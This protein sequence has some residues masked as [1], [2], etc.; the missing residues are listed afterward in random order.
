MEKTRPTFARD[1]GFRRAVTRSVERYFADAE[2][3]PHGDRRMILKAAVTLA[4]FAASYA[5]LVF[6]A[7]TWW[8]G[9]GASLSLALATA[10]VGFNIQH[11]ANHG[12]FSKRRRVNRL[13]GLTIDVLGGSSFVWRATHNVFHHSYPNLDGA[14]RDI[15]LRPLARLA[16]T[17]P[18][19][20]VH[21][22][23]HYYLWL[24]YG[25]LVPAWHFKDVRCA[26]TGRVAGHRFPRPRGRALAELVAGK[27]L[28][29]GY[30]LVVPALF[31]P[32]LVV[33]SFYALTAFATGL[34]LSTVFQ[35][36]HCVVEA[37][38]PEPPRG[39]QMADGW[40]AHQVQTTVDFAPGNRFLAWYLGG[41]SYQIEHHLFPR[42]CHIHYPAIAPIVRNV[43]SDFGVRYKVHETLRGALASHFRWLRCMGRAT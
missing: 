32:L 34:V 8:Q 19:R 28:F 38:F 31:H 5:L 35:L 6:V 40:A 42:V 3:S 30:A 4:W 27:L 16:P 11:D 33:I 21:R 2:R 15:D 18:R 10:S 22:F 13:L 12:A 39:G 29:V 23:Q 26:A 1:P 7:R 20:R 37:R 14:D 9:V 43:C 25:F 24:L 36:A 41:L 17:Q